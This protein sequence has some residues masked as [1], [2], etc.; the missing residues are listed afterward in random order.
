MFHF[1][2]NSV[3][4]IQFALATFILMVA[5]GV[6]TGDMAL[7]I[8][9]GA[10]FALPAVIGALMMLE[11]DPTETPEFLRE[12]LLVEGV[13]IGVTLGLT[14]HHILIGLAAGVALGL[15]LRAS[16]EHQGLKATPDR[17]LL[18]AFAIGG[19]FFAA[20]LGI[21]IG[22]STTSP[23]IGIIL[24]VVFLALALAAT[25]SIARQL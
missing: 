22:L 21:I 5:V 4:G 16:V 3:P 14:V 9:F 1:N 13:A 23:L 2:R 12:I 11:T 18:I 15:T 8:A 24:G 19:V 10:I 17:D 20:L 25:L 6:L 7:W